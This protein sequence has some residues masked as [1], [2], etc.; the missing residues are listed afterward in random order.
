MKV[1]DVYVY[2]CETEIVYISAQALVRIA[3]CETEIGDV[4]TWPHCV[5]EIPPPIA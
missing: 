3:V 2:V 5:V 1:K 4:F